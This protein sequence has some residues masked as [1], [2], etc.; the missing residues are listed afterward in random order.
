[1]STAITADIIQPIK[2]KLECHPVY[3]A[4]SSVDD[5]KCF[6]QHHVYSVW[7]FM[8]LVK[9]VQASIA[10]TTVPWVPDG[11]GQVRRF[12]NEL[13]LEEEC[14]ET[15]VPGQYASH[16]EL[17][18]RAMTEVGAGTS[19]SIAFMRTVKEKGVSFALEQSDIPAPSRLF[20]QS[21]FGFIRNDKP[22]E[23]AAA[24]ALG[25]EHI[26]P[27]M[28]RAILAKAGIP[29]Q[30][31]PIFHFYLNRHVD[32]D[33]GSHAPLSLRLLNALCG[34]DQ[35]KIHESIDAAHKAVAARIR[36]WDGV[37]D[38]LRKRRKAA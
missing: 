31:A 32:L 35:K 20:T 38:A 6:M 9:C 16:L 18:L 10:P 36:L 2:N 23:A 22:H 24:L 7:D 5:L 1:M 29:E 28:F 26:I 21:T 17:Y 27:A 12:I 3:E 25:R 13:V 8:S 15:N 11:D 34:D 4:V 30:D 19:T 33:E 14:D 37:L